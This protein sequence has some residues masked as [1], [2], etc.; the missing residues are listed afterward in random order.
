VA[1]TN[2]FS[3]NSAVLITTVK[4]FV[5]QVSVGKIFFKILSLDPVFNF[6]KLKRILL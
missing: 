6:F 5:L 4:S 2:T 3:Y 1:V